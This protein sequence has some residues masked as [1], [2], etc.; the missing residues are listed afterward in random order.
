MEKEK[1]EFG[2]DCRICG[3]EHT[4]L[5]NETDVCHWQDGALIQDVL[6]YL[7]ASERELFIS[8]T[9]DNCWTEMFGENGDYD[10]GV[11]FQDQYAIM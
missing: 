10:S 3:D 5:A 2:V 6:P 9:C 8:G 11:D 4:I 7:T 1:F